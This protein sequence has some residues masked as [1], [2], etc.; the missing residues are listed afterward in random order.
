MNQIEVIILSVLEKKKASSMITGICLEDLLKIEDFGYTSATFYK[1]IQ[2]LKQKGYIEN[3]LK[4]GRR[5]T[6]FITESGI[7]F[8]KELK[9]GFYH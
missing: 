1:Y 6:Y 4:N 5:Y 3:G 7:T 9:G 8:L 2:R